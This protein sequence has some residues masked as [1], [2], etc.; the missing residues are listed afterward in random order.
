MN[1]FNTPNEIVDYLLFNKPNDI[2]IIDEKPYEKMGN[3]ANPFLVFRAELY[4]CNENFFKGCTQQEVTGI[5][6]QWWKIIPDS[7]KN[8]YKKI[9]LEKRSKREK[10]KK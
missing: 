2:I 9:S 6:A 7:I 3:G 10:E 1:D 5:T 8:I 4:K